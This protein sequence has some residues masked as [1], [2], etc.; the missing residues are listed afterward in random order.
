MLKV[1]KPELE[2]LWFRESMMSD[3]E[4]M[5]YNDAWGGTIPFP[6]EDWEEWYTLWVRNSGQER[7]YRYLKDDANKVFVGEIS[8]HFDKLR[9]IYICDVIIKA[10]FRKQGFGTQGIQ[11]LCEAAKAN[12]VEAL[13]D[14]IAADNPSAHLFLKNGFSIEFQNDEILMVKTVL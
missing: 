10:E 3:I 8:Y 14:N 9:N 2:D 6:K 12:G 13:Y 11:L 7:Y 1:V 5:S 4:T